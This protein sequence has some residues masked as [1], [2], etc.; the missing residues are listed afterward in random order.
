[1]AT[2]FAV[3]ATGSLKQVLDLW[4]TTTN[5]EHFCIGCWV[6]YLKEYGTEEEKLIVEQS[7]MPTSEAVD[8]DK[9][10]SVSC[11]RCHERPKK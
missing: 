7:S 11:C 4:H 1:M 8:P 6:M 3:E 9:F 2:A 10:G 5:G